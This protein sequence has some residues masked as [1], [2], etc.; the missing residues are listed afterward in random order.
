MIERAP[1]NRE[2]CGFLLGFFR[3][4]L[5]EVIGY[6]EVENLSNNP[7]EFLMDPRGVLKAYEEARSRGTDLVGL[8]HTHPGFL[9]TPSHKDLKGM[10]LWPIPWLIIGLLS[11]DTRAWI[12]CEGLLKE[13]RIRWIQS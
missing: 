11:N 6:K 13:L 1:K 9:A 7:Y 8:Y 4:A 10:E 3:D 12:L 2:V 5:V